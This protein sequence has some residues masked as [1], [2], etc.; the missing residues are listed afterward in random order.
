M[1]LGFGSAPDIV[2][3]KVRSSG[4]GESSMIAC[5]RTD[6]DLDFG[7]R[8]GYVFFNVDSIFLWY[9]DSGE[10]ISYKFT[11]MTEVSIFPQI[12]GG[13]FV[14]GGG[15]N[16]IPAA[17]FSNACMKQFYKLKD[18][19]TKVIKG[20]ELKDSDFYLQDNRDLCPK[21]G[22]AFPEEGR[23]V[24]PRCIDRRS[25]FLRVLGYFKPYAGS[26]AL[27][28]FI[29]L[30]HGMVSSVVPFLSGRVL[31]D[32][33]LNKSAVP[34]EPAEGIY[35]YIEFMLSRE[36]VAAL[37]ILILTILSVRILHQLLGILQGRM[38]AGIMPKAVL[39]IKS[40]IYKSMQ[41]LSIGFF[42]LRQTG[43]LMTRIQ[44]DA[45][46]VMY[47][48]IDGLPYLLVN[49]VI[50]VTAA[51]VMISMNISLAVLALIFI[52]LLF[53]ISYRMIPRLWHLHG[54]RHRSVRNMNS[55]V[56]DNLTGARVVKAFGQ[57]RSETLR[58]EMINSRVRDAELDLV[59]YDNKFFGAYSAVETVS[60]LIIWGIG[61][62]FVLKG[63]PGMT[64]GTLT[65]FV[66]YVAMLNGPLDFMSFIFRWWSLSMNSAQRIFEVIDAVPEVR[67]KDVPV[68][69]GVFEGR[70]DVKD[71]SFS[72]TPDKR[73]LDKMSFSITPGTYFGIVGKS[74][75]GKT[76]L[77]NLIS[78]FYDVK[79]GQI[80]IDGIPIKDLA[81]EDIRKNIAI[82]SQDSYIFSGTIAENIAYAKPDCSFKEIVSAA[83]SAGAH[84]FIMKLPHGY[85]TVV[86]H[87]AKDLSGGE[88]QR[89]SIARAILADPRIL[90]L[91]E[92][93]ASVDTHTE[94]KIQRSLDDLVKN[95]T[96]ISIA[97]RLS[98]LRDAD[99]L[100]VIEDGKVVEQGTH[101]QLKKMKGV[102]NK[103]LQLQTKALAIKGAEEYE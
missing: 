56:S 1:E 24:C 91:D 67:E 3:T 65:A 96:T 59:D 27:I 58:F 4:I 39:N 71:V 98:T 73:I 83:A 40:D 47:F 7:V 100:I 14:I 68:R 35:G 52:P 76:T 74:G 53:L 50:L 87:G 48:F 43:S 34:S 23:Q 72:Y 61:S 33:V 8:K 102:Y 77:I 6:R 90:I 93:T 32:N 51:V 21:C 64:Y 89:I 36:S 19:I 22:N 95:R 30:V 57:E 28:M 38:V 70:I 80:S 41:K 31:Y 45:T 81:F 26:F 29:I 92:A 44:S 15:E 82:V 42:N 9:T 99:D 101:E 55:A 94:Q 86:G 16:G 13:I 46:E 2:K 103:L 69:K 49:I 37:G 84:D 79:E 12:T 97:H 11:G 20:E 17:A 25:L 66:A 85:D 54:K 62:W 10:I 88:K 60:S 18:L 75:A 5:V 63:Y 78:R